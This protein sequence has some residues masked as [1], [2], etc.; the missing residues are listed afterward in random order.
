MKKFAFRLKRVLDLRVAHEKM[1]L[2]DFGRE[3][4]ALR[5]ESE[6]L[7]LFQTE[8]ESQFAEIR[9]DRA[10]PFAVWNQNVNGRYLA[11]IG[12]VVEFQSQR[13]RQQE[14]SV[15]TARLIY[16]DARRDTR[17]LEKLRET[18]WQD[19]NVESLREENNVLDEV[20]GRRKADEVG[21]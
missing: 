4:Q 10:A 19:W 6:K 16:L 1:K 15:E 13:V 17:V 12:R 18:Q 7:A 8:A 20:G 2:A 5:S 21:Q 3:Q 14:C 9:A 11:R